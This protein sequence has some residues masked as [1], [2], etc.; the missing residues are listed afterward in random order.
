[1]RIIYGDYYT[2][3]IQFMLQPEKFGEFLHSWSLLC[4]KF[5]L[6]VESTTARARNQHCSWKTQHIIIRWF[7]SRWRCLN[8]LYQCITEYANNV[9]NGE[10]KI[11]DFNISWASLMVRVSSKQRCL[12]LLIWN[13]LSSL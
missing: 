1:V 3:V 11:Y 7:R 13:L 12:P 2:P 9:L 10:Y 8:L 6:D 4:D 5:C